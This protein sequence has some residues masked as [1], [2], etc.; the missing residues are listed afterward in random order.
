MQNWTQ[1]PNSITSKSLT[2]HYSFHNTISNYPPSLPMQ[3]RL[4]YTVYF[5]FLPQLHR[6]QN[7]CIILAIIQ[8]FITISTQANKQI[9]YSPQ[10]HKFTNSLQHIPVTMQNNHIF[11]QAKLLSLIK[12]FQ[13]AQRCTWLKQVIPGKTRAAE[14]YRCITQ[15]LLSSRWNAEPRPTA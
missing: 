8:C 1:L 12:I 11:H 14:S 3:F 7:S 10:T 6:L 15:G 4:L 2:Y 13:C 5:L 9:N